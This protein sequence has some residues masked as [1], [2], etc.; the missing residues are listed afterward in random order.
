MVTARLPSAGNPRGNYSLKSSILL[1]PY[2]T[3]P[4]AP[5]K[6][7]GEKYFFLRREPGQKHVNTA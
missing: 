4:G 5:V 2:Y 7:G 3:I 6:G 1:W